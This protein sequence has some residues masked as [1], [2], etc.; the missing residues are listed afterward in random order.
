MLMM[1]ED[2][3]GFYGCGTGSTK[4]EQKMKSGKEGWLG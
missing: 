1:I 3:E 2:V 4:M